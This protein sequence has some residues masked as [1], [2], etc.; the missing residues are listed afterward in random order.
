MIVWLLKHWAELYL[1]DESLQGQDSSA[2]GSVVNGGPVGL[3][4]WVA[5]VREENKTEPG[6]FEK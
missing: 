4:I 1:C 6:L 2:E 3:N 5:D